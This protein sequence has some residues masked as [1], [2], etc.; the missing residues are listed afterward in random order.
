[1]NVAERAAADFATD[2]K[3]AADAH[4]EQLLAVDYVRFIGWLLLLLLLG[5]CARGARGCRGG[6]GRCRGGG[7]GVGTGDGQRRGPLQRFWWRL[8]HGLEEE[9]VSSAQNTN[10]AKAGGRG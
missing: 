6:S 3:L 4:I 7:D 9:G 8:R 1:V 2:R 5:R 10:A